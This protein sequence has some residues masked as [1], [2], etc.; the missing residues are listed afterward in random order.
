MGNGW[1]VAQ[2]EHTH[3][4]VQLTHCLMGAWFVVPTPNN[5]SGNIKDQ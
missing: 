3:L 2:S 1:S 4:S 5:D